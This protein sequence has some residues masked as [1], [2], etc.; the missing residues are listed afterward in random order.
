MDYKKYSKLDLFPC[1]YSRYA[2]VTAAITADRQAMHQ[3]GENQ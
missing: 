3:G 1:Q 2:V